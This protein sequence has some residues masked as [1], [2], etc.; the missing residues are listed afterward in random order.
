MAV[1]YRRGKQDIVGIQ[2]AGIKGV[3]TGLIVRVN[4]DGFFRCPAIPLSLTER[5][6]VR[7]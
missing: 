4:G 1:A 7:G 6:G 3:K 5:I 2:C